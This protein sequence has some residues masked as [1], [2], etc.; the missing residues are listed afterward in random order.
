MITLWFDEVPGGWTYFKEMAQRLGHSGMK[1]IVLSPR[2]NTNNKRIEVFGN[3]KV[4]RCSSFYFPKIPLFFVN[5]LSFLFTLK[6][7]FKNED[8]IEL[9]YDTTS[10]LLP[11]SPIANIFFKLISGVKIPTVVY[12]LGELK[13][14]GSKKTL[15]LL[16]ESYLQLVA[17]LCY[18]MADKLLLAGKKL[19]HRVLRLGANPNKLQIVRVG[20]KYEN[21]LGTSK[22]LTNAEKIILKNSIGLS[23]NDFVIGYVGRLS[24]GKGLDILLNAI[25]IVKEELPSVKVLI[26][27]DGEEWG[28][29]ELLSSKLSIDDVTK[30]L[31]YRHD[32]LDLM[33]IMD[34]FV[35]LSKSEADISATQLEAMY[36]RIPSIITP[37]TDFMEN[38]KHVF[39]VPFDDVQAVVDAILDLYNSKEKRVLLGI[40]GSKKAQEILN[41]YSWDSHLQSIICLFNNLTGV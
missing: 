34:L 17:R 21:K 12:I 33:Q 32:V 11:L 9:I 40:N 4:Y 41:L 6:D 20:L 22:H 31:G 37:F 25:S 8:K 38:M 28:K 5:P 19:S 16:F 36:Y 39:V 15:S 13:E 7:I 18:S 14:F 24:L 23:Q 26:V 3:V 1:I 35:N 29:L 27:G 2:A 10:G 30:F